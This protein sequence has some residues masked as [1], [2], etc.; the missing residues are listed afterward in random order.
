MGGAGRI[1]PNLP[2]LEHAVAVHPIVTSFMTKT[3]GA[4][5]PRVTEVDYMK[6]GVFKTKGK[7]SLDNRL[8]PHE[9]SKDGV[10]GMALDISSPTDKLI[11]M[12]GAGF[13]SEPTFY[14]KRAEEGELTESAVKLI[15]AVKEFIRL[16]EHP[17]DIFVIANWVRNGL[18]LRTTAAVIMAIAAR[19]L[20]TTNR[21]LM[22][23]YASSVF[24]RTDD[25]VSCFA[26]YRHY[27]Q[28]TGDGKHK[29]TV[30]ASLRKSFASV[31][32]TTPPALL[33]KYY[34]KNSSPNLRDVLL[35]IR[36]KSPRKGMITI[37]TVV[38]KYLVNEVVP[39]TDESHN[40]KY[41]RAH[42]AFY[43]NTEFTTETIA[44]AK[45]L[46]LTWENVVSH[47]GSTTAVWE[48]LITNGM[49]GYMALLRNLRNFVKA[50]I[51]DA[52]WDKV[53]SV[54][55]DKQNVKN[56]RQ[57][58]FRYYAAYMYAS[59][60]ANEYMTVSMQRAK[61]IASTA[62]DISVASVPRLP[63]RTVVIIDNSGSMV[64]RISTKSELHMIDVANTLGAILAKS[65]PDCIVGTF[66]ERWA[67]V[68][69]WNHNDSTMSIKGQINQCGLTTGHAT[70]LVPAIEW[71][72]EQHIK[73][74]RIIVLSDM[75]AYDVYD[76]V[77][78]WGRRT[79]MGVTSLYDHPAKAFKAYRKKVPNV[80]L[81]SIN[82]A[83]A[84]QAQFDPIDKNVWLLSGWSNQL[85]DLIL[86]LEQASE[87]AGV[88]VPTINELRKQYAIK[89]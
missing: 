9:H 42:A 3:I 68:R 6:Y 34:R 13:F 87:K 57:L 52:A 88:K 21:K 62:L 85:W 69:D 23:P 15:E 39:V 45:W 49:M 50:H 14:G 74:D 36:N 1:S 83:G 65:Q 67:C 18:N 78:Q 80:K 73:T 26:F 28:Q 58:P 56:S 48:A 79:R 51:S 66:G 29:G 72:I 70:R 11:H 19:E 59:A 44:T 2:L 40:H 16:Q 47:F 38:W 64:Q 60:D 8:V 77:K 41:V 22:R 89:K 82:M 43:K 81:Y 76:N 5:F 31:L 71:L 54:L 84:S 53:E 12:V 61:V 30:P 55:T 63:G 86:K 25:I 10:L 27:Y 32:S 17:D 7:H 35:M 4:Y 33:L 20:P 37:P 75:N 46:G 24:A